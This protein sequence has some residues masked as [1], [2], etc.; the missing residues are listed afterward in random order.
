MER[1]GV[2]LVLIA[3]S[4]SAAI[5][6]MVVFLAANAM[7]SLWVSLPISG[8]LVFLGVALGIAAVRS[9]RE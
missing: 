9:K 1:I 7:A 4:I 8:M 5:C 6:V 3:A 2:T